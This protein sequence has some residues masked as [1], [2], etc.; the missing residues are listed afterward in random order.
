[1][2]RFIDLPKNCVLY[3][4][5]IDEET[6]EISD[7][8]TFDATLIEVADER[9]FEIHRDNK[10]YYLPKYKESTEV[11]YEL[12]IIKLFIGTSVGAVDRAIE[13][14]IEERKISLEK[15]IASYRKDIR[16]LNRYIKNCEK[17]L[18]NLENK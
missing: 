2:L 14:W 4:K 5:A 10:N 8:V 12:P 3:S 1:M 15:C 17:K 18:K 6:F 7:L 16:Q 13:G 9:V 11:L